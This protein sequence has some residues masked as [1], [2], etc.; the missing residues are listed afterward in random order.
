[1]NRRTTLL[2]TAELLAWWTGIAALWLVLV[3]T[4]DVL[5]VSVGAGCAAA[6]ALA[7]RAARRAVTGR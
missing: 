3:S 4:V 5:E 1:M 7:A 6:G 2:A